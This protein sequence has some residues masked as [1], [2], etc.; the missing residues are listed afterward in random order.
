MRAILPRRSTCSGTAASAPTSRRP[1]ETHADVGDKANDAIRVDG[2]ELRA[3]VVG[4]GGNLGLTQLGRIEFALAGGAASTPTP[5]TTR[6]ASTPPTTRSTSRSCSTR[7][8]ARALTAEQRNE[9]LAEMTD[10]VGRM[11]LRR[12]L[13]AE[14]PARQRAGPG[15]RRCSRCTSASSARWKSAA[16]STARWSSC[17]PT[18]RSTSGCGRHRADLPELAVLV[19]YSKMTLTRR[20]SAHRP[21]GRAVV[22]TALRRYFPDPLVERFDDRL[23]RHPLRREIIT[24]SVVNDLVNRGG[25]TFVFRAKEETGASPPA[26]RPRLHASCARSSASTTCGPRSR[27]STTRCPPTSRTRSTSRAAGCSTAAPAGCCRAAGASIDVA[28]RSSTSR[29]GSTHCSPRVPEFLVG[30]EQRAAAASGWP[31][32]PTVGVPADLALARGGLLDAFSLLDVVEIAAARETAGRRG[33]GRLLRAVGALRGR[34]DAHPDHRAAARR[35]VVG[36]GPVGAALRPLRRAGPPDDQRAHLD[37]AERARTG[38]HRGVG[39]S[40]TPRASPAPG[41]RST[42]SPRRTTSTWRR[43]RWPCGRSAPCSAR[44]DALSTKVDT[45]PV[46]NVG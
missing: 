38:A 36:A 1:R 46:V 39:G 7:S 18:T 11:V 13:R 31:S 43:C 32:S 40:R 35:P 41:A 29:P 44:S 5:S 26:D 17:P 33:R 28:R 16:S 12:Q 4:E 20:S 34:P 6:P 10:D 37:V 42:R 30:T 22:R 45:R 14:R 15:A 3:R 24:T 23:G 9:L 2:A 21:A 27:R 19:A 25:I 8:C